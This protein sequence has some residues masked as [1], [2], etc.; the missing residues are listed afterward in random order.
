MS[1]VT[2]C[3][4]FTSVSSPTKRETKQ[5]ESRK[6]HFWTI[7][8]C[9]FYILYLFSSFLEKIYHD[10]PGKIIWQSSPKFSLPTLLCTQQWLNSSCRNSPERFAILFRQYEYAK[11]N[12]IIYWPRRKMKKWIPKNYQH[13]IKIFSNHLPKMKWILLNNSRDAIEL[14]TTP[15]SAYIN[16]IYYLCQSLL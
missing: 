9:F 5:K 16:N 4:S 7:F 3:G 10:C 8:R 15:C 12:M 2:F 11:L 14:K 6:L 1:L 13:S